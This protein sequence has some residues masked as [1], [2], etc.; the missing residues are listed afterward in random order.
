MPFYLVRAKPRLDLLPVLRLQ[1]DLGEFLHLRPFGR[2]LT[3]SLKGARWDA[4]NGQAVWE[5]EDY[6]NPPL[7]QEREAVLDRYFEDVDVQAVV[8][9]EGWR[10]ISNLPSLW[11]LT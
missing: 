10:Q 5:E 2:A 7:A 3:A 1:L 6:C 8:P 11:T 4:T 9:G